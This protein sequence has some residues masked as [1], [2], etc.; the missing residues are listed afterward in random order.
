MLILKGSFS[1]INFLVNS[2]F[3]N[4]ALSHFPRT[5]YSIPDR[6]DLR[7]S[8]IPVVPARHLPAMLRNARQ[9]GMKAKKFNSP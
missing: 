3:A 2:S 6:R 5:H 1:S 8:S 7:H 4:K 9:A